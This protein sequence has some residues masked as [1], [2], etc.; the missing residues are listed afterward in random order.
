MSFISKGIKKNERRK[1]KN[2]GKGKKGR[3]EK[4]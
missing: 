3:K 2:K 4:R 1:R